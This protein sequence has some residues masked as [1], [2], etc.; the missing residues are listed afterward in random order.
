MD[1][2]GENIVC[3]MLAWG[4]CATYVCVSSRKWKTGLCNSKKKS[5]IEMKVETG[6]V[7]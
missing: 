4:C 2:D 3:N 7:C 6:S 5:G 1:G